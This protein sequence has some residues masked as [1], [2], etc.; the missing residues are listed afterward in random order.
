[1]DANYIIYKIEKGSKLYL[2]DFKEQTSYNE[3]YASFGLS[4]SKALLLNSMS[5]HSI[6][7]R[8]NGKSNRFS[9]E[10]QLHWRF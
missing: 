5:A 2:L 3:Y 9:M 6:I 1:M 7:N 8:M 4:K 10:K